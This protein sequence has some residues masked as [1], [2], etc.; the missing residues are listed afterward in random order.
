M[1][2]P[3]KHGTQ[4]FAHRGP[5]A[6]PLGFTQDMMLFLEKGSLHAAPL[7]TRDQKK[8]EMLLLC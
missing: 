8:P 7:R 4:F 1:F 5:V 6:I 3:T 2:L